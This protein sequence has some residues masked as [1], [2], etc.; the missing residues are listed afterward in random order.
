MLVSKSDD[1]IVRSVQNDLQILFGLSRTRAPLDNIFGEMLL[2]T[3]SFG[4][5]VRRRVDSDCDCELGV[6]NKEI[7]VISPMVRRRSNPKA[8]DLNCGQMN[9]GF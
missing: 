6:L 5:G 7:G 1:D 3:W 4:N 9:C 8:K 2:D